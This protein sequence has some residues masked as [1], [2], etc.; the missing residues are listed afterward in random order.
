MIE[1]DLLMSWR[2]KADSTNALEFRHL[3]KVTV[4]VPP[5]WP[6]PTAHIRVYL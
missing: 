2:R 5:I 3:P 4:P 6:F 1:T